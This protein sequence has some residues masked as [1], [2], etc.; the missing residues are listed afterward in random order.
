[1]KQANI[2]KAGAA[3]DIVYLA[4]FLCQTDGAGNRDE[5]Y[6]AD[7]SPA[8]IERLG[9]DISQ[10]EEKKTGVTRWV[11]ELSEALTFN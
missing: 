3:I 8:V 2:I 11:E 5:T 6:C 4:N 9:L 1:M 10:F 7:L